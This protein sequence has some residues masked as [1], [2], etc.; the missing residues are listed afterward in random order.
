VAVDQLRHLGIDVL[1]LDLTSAKIPVVGV[2]T[3][4]L[5]ENKFA[6]TI[7]ARASAPSALLILNVG[8]RVI[9]RCQSETWSVFPTDDDTG[10][11]P[12]AALYI[13]VNDLA[14]AFLDSLR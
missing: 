4:L 9:M 1:R 11:P 7:S 5:D 10:S 13:R 3:W 14:A 2:V 8:F 6:V 12:T